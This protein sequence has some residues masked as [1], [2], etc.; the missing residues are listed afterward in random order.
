MKNK[1][2]KKELLKLFYA[3]Y[4]RI[5]E[6][7]E[8]INRLNVFPVPDGDTGTNLVMTMEKGMELNNYDSTDDKDIFDEIID[9][10][11]FNARG[12]SGVILTQYFIGLKNS[13]TKAKEI[14]IETLIK[15]FQ[16]AYEKA[17]S[18]IK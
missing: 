8:I 16:T 12:N 9:N 14:T 15:A 5:K 13:L 17:Y 1:I 3:G 2:T 6:E 4:L 7:K 18:S 10:M 11:A